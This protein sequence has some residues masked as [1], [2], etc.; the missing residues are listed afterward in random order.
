MGTVANHSVAIIDPLDGTNLVAL[1]LQRLAELDRLRD[2]AFVQLN[3]LNEATLAVP[4]DQLLVTMCGP[5][6]SMAEFDRFSRAVRQITVLEFE[7][8]GLFWAPDRNSPRKPRL[9]K[10]DRPGFVP[11]V[12]L[13]DPFT[14][15]DM[16]NPFDIRPDYR[17]G[18]LDEVVAGIRKTLGAEAPADD[19][20]A[21][22][23]EK[24]VQPA[25]P[26]PAK[27]PPKGPEYYMRARPAEPAPK[28]A[29]AYVE[30]AQNDPAMKAALLAI[31]N[32]DNKGFRQPSKAKIKKHR[33]S[34][35]P[36]K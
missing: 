33:M 29:P 14:G 35:G 19:P 9:V 13:P 11:P 5:K 1:T 4:N 24:L 3:R 21:P 32:L 27:T 2:F 22:P 31:R 8:R 7:L 23:P 36:P 25:E 6:G 17:N 10:S 30:H 26:A 34:R 12:N 15:F 16:D 28:P 18:P 20:F